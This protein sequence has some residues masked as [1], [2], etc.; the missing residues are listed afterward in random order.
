MRDQGSET[1]QR[2]SQEAGD[3]PCGSLAI[4]QIWLHFT[5]IHS[6]MYLT[7]DTR[8]RACKSNKFLAPASFFKKYKRGSYIKKLINIHPAKQPG[9]SVY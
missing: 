2:A 8:L 1:T 4:L 3:D 5:L 7:S 6:C 9:T